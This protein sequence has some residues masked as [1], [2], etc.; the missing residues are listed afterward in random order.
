VAGGLTQARGLLFSLD[1]LFEALLRRALAESLREGSLTLAAGE[2]QL[3]LLRSLDGG[4]ESLALKPDFLFLKG[5]KG[6]VLVGDAKWKR[7]TDEAGSLGL[8]PSDVYQLATYMARHG[9]RRGVLFFPMDEWMTPNPDGYWSR[10]F[11]L[12][13][14]GGHISVVAVDI[15]GLVSRDQQLRQRAIASLRF[16]LAKAPNDGLPSGDRIVPLADAKAS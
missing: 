14:G 11:E 3:H 9:L 13:G 2:R 8:A 6:K 4:A 10:D 5:P 16:A 12:I 15:L 1:D 7:L